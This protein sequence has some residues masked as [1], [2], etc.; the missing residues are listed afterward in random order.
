MFCVN[1]VWTC[2]LLHE[3][4]VEEAKLQFVS[5]TKTAA[6]PHPLLAHKTLDRFFIE[7]SLV[8]NV[9]K[10]KAHPGIS[11]YKIYGNQRCSKGSTEVTCEYD[12]DPLEK[13]PDPTT[14]LVRSTC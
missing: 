2:K 8:Q 3:L 10:K 4:V 12:F 13:G 1:A 7:P 5:T 6:F 14:R 9:N 11:L